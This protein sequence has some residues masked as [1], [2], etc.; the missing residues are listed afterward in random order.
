MT[1]GRP[2]PGPL[3]SALINTASTFGGGN[4]G[5]SSPPTSPG[6]GYAD[7]IRG[8]G[9][10]APAA[11]P[12]AAAAS[13]DP[14][15]ASVFVG[16][17]PVPNGP[18]VGPAAPGTT[19]T[20]A[21]LLRE[22]EQMDQK[23]QRRLALLLAVGGY[24]GSVGLEDAGKAARDMT[25]N[26]TLNAYLELLDDAAG[27]FSRGQLITP[28]NLLEQNVAYRLPRGSDWDGTFQDL[29]HVLRENDISIDGI[30]VTP[31]DGTDWEKEKRQRERERDKMEGTRTSTSTDTATDT[32]VTRDIM[33][34]N[35]A[36]ALTRAMLQRE[37][38]R[39]PTKAEMEDFVA[40][41]QAAQRSNPTRTS[42]STTR[43]TVQSETTNR[44]GRT[45]DSS[46]D[47]D[48][49][50]SSTQQSGITQ[51]GIQDILLRRTRANPDWAEWQ[52]VGTYAPALFE[53]LGATV[54]GV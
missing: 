50:S 17:G 32:S 24:A 51:A 33:D 14:L 11:G 44:R 7:Q 23:A 38:D 45:V 5:Y 53:A 36:M 1:Q 3:T 35:D 30:D 18:V 2:E 25:L 29:T 8:A 41:V 9:G 21:Q 28:E 15:N 37:L 16:N 54:P 10:G 13:N 31:D 12:A 39:D 46:S 47:V 6:S 40:A 52:A 49:S 34:P 19:R 20:M 27:R 22:F 26:E 42:S 4:G 48:T 43:T